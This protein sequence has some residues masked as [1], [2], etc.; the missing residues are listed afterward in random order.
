VLA[1]YLIRRPRDETWVASVDPHFLGN[2]RLSEARLETVGTKS[3]WYQLL[4]PPWPVKN[5]HWVIDVVKATEVATGSADRIWEQW[6]NLTDDGERIALEVTAAGRVPE[7]PLER[8]LKSRYLEENVGAW[9]LFALED[10]LTLVVY[11]LTVVMG[12]WIPDRLTA[13]FAMGALEEL[14]QTVER[15]AGQITEHYDADHR[16]IM[17]GDGRIIPPFRIAEALQPTPDG[18][19]G[20]EGSDG[21]EPGEEGRQG[22]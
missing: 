17:G 3:V 21:D 12:G 2:D 13:R 14:M 11:Q 5:R 20:R 9:T 10:E 18:E 6:W 15:A 16:P 22:D 8:A 19:A 4:D 1:Y 7:V